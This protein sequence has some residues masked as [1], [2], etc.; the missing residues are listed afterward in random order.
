MTKKAEDGFTI[1]FEGRAIDIQTGLVGGVTGDDLNVPIGMYAGKMEMEEIGLC[2][3][4]VHRVIL[5][6]FI[7]H[8]GL[9]IKAIDEFI[10]LCKNE[11]IKRELRAN[12][13]EKMDFEEYDK[14]IKMTK[15]NS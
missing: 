7:E 5:K 1:I 9:N 3:I 12:E 2:L 13:F 4:H 15:D 8:Y 10:C 11:A 6:M 14:L